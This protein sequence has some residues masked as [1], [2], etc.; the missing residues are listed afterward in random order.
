MAVVVRWAGAMVVGHAARAGG[1]SRAVIAVVPAGIAERPSGCDR[2]AGNGA[3]AAIAAVDGDVVLRLRV[4]SSADVRG[5]R[6]GC[7]G[8]GVIARLEGPGPAPMRS[9]RRWTGP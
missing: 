9:Q 7:P 6:T 3:K 1:G 5:G 4:R 8:I 2:V